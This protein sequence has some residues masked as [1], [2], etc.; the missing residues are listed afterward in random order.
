M[1]IITIPAGL[2]IGTSRGTVEE[3]APTVAYVESIGEFTS[4]RSG[5]FPSE[6]TDPAERI[7]Y[8]YAQLVAQRITAAAGPLAFFL[9]V[10]FPAR[11][12]GRQVTFIVTPTAFEVAELRQQLPRVAPLDAANP[13]QLAEFF[14]LHEIAHALDPFIDGHLSD[15]ERFATVS[16]AHAILSTQNAAPAL[17]ALAD[18]LEAGALD[19]IFPT[20]AERVAHRFGA[21][22]VK[23]IGDVAAGR[24]S[25]DLVSA[26]RAAAEDVA[27]ARRLRLYRDTAA[28]IGSLMLGS[29]RAMFGFSGG[30]DSVV[31]A[32]LLAPYRDQVSMAWVNTGMGF[33]HADRFIRESAADW[34]FLEIPS[35][36]AAVWAK[37]GR[38]FNI[39]PRKHST[40]L[41]SAP[42]EPRMQSVES[43]CGAAKGA[44]LFEAFRQSDAKLL[45]LGQRADD[46]NPTLRA[47]VPQPEGRAWV[48]PLWDWT[49]EDVDA[50]A[51]MH[52]LPLPEQYSTFR[53]SLDC[54]C[55][56]A[57]DAKRRR[58][59]A[60]HHPLVLRTVDSLSA[61]MRAAVSAAAKEVTI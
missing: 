37:G 43:C 42:D 38:P 8:G 9:G 49:D 51:A 34:R 50:Y 15:V 35:T 31:L 20:D 53:D 48:C 29:P 46:G 24:K 56:P 11:I 12:P 23:A 2:R 21:A 1:Q 3:S 55:C 14:R 18:A 6:I 61:D 36:L 5:E 41:R 59:L 22:I 40:Q 32:H 30:I 13:A 16:A 60:D 47:I 39:I 28:A 7:G 44:P 19:G 10:A 27:V 57:I 58:Y 4:R 25:A 33:P 54:W 26:T 52:R 17:L 45:F